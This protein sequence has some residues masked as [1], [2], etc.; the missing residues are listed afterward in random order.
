MSP[1]QPKSRGTL[2]MVTAVFV[3]SPDALLISLVG[4]DPWVLIFWRGLLT[5]STLTVAMI[6][7]R[8]GRAFGEAMKL[9]AAGI[10]TGLFFGMSTISF[11]LSVRM[12]SAANTLVIIAAMPLFSAILTRVFTGE[13]VPGR[14]W[15][16]VAAGFAGI[17]VVFSGSVTKGNPAGDLLALLTALLMASNFVIIRRNSHLNMIPAVILSGVLT[18]L[19]TAFISDPLSPGTGDILML[20]VMGSVV[21]PIPLAL[22]TV[23]PKLIPAAEVGLIMLL[24]TFLGPFWVWL[25]LGEKPPGETLLGGGIL[26]ATLALHAV[27]GLRKTDMGVSEYGGVGE[28]QTQGR[29]DTEENRCRNAVTRRRTD[30]KTQ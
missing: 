13:K 16:A 1:L 4:S 19:V 24:E 30:T 18:S 3:L 8:G 21:L 23:A 12:T 29:G 14:T 10:V 28:K 11:V 5:A 6:C 20:V 9:G 7:A 17:A 26:I 2:L 27:A 22:M 15:A 25:A